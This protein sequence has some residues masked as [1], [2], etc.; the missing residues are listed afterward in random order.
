MYLRRGS[1]NALMFAL[2][3]VQ[4]LYIQLALYRLASIDC[5]PMLQVPPALVAIVTIQTQAETLRAEFGRVAAV[6]RG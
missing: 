1:G 2:V 3:G 4:S 6:D 5:G